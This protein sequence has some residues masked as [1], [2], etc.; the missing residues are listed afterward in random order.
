MHKQIKFDNE[1]YQNPVRYGN[2]RLMKKY[3]KN[4]VIYYDQLKK[5]IYE[6]EQYFDRLNS[7]KTK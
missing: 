2:D 6:L 4:L 3:S 7:K 1:V 5:T